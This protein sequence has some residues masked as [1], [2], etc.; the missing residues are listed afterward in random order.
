[1]RKRKIES[2]KSLTI[3]CFFF[4]SLWNEK[5]WDRMH[6]TKCGKRCLGTA[7]KHIHVYSRIVDNKANEHRLKP[8]ETNSIDFIVLLEWPTHFTAI[9]LA[10]L[11]KLKQYQCQTA[12]LAP[13]N[14]VSHNTI[15]S[16]RLFA[17][18][19]CLFLFHFT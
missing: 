19:I 8:D 10:P 12:T 14:T 2:E 5:N 11:H 7:M 6:W 4:V 1:M 17:L 15:E 18:D 3:I 16:F 13:Q 9:S